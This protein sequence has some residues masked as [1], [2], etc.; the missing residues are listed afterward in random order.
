MGLAADR[1]TLYRT[2]D[3]AHFVTR[4]Q[5]RDLAVRGA[6]SMLEHPAFL[7]WSG[8]TGCPTSVSIRGTEGSNPPPSSGE[9]D[10]NR[11]NGYQGELPGTA[12]PK[13]SRTHPDQC[14]KFGSFPEKPKRQKSFPS[15]IAERSGTEPTT[16]GY[17]DGRWGCSGE[18]EFKDAA[19]FPCDILHR[20]WRDAGTF[21]WASKEG[22]AA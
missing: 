16:S 1:P 15:S 17:A 21:R 3:P 9:S 20:M 18:S 8:R 10:A 12:F 11:R 5:Q 22:Q 4:R 14:K 13:L 19:R 6:S 2:K 7:S